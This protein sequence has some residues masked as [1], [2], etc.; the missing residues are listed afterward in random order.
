M[1]IFYHY[2]DEDED[3]D[4]DEGAEEYRPGLSAGGSL[5][6]FSFDCSSRTRE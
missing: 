2:E 3:E 5:S 1:F 4:E 6:S